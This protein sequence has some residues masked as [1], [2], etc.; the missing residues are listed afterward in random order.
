MSSNFNIVAISVRGNFELSDVFELCVWSL[1][2]LSRDSYCTPTDRL[3]V[4]Q[5]KKCRRL[6]FVIISVEMET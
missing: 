3:E 5:S 2:K 6:Y 1:M 4:L